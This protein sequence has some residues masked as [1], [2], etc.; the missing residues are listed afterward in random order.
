M[1]LP[2]RLGVFGH[3]L[4][5]WGAEF[6]AGDQLSRV[7]SVTLE[8][9]ILVFLPSFLCRIFVALYFYRSSHHIT[10]TLT[11]LPSNRSL[12]AVLLHLLPSP[13]GRRRPV[14]SRTWCDTRNRLGAWDPLRRGRPML[15]PLC[16]AWEY[17][18]LDVCAGGGQVRVCGAFEGY[19]DGECT[20]LF[21]L[22][23][24]Y[25]LVS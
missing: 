6:V 25:F 12:V 4:A 20:V 22:S 7:A 8:R 3:I 1:L 13:Q 17:P 11:P 9:Q 16:R 21:F 15:K 18:R 14:R 23:F 5:F 10:D 2:W 19:G 24:F